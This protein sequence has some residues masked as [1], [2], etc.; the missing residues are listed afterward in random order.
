MTFGKSEFHHF[1]FSGFRDQKR[2][3][4]N[5]QRDFNNQ[6]RPPP[7]HPRDFEQQRQFERPAD[8]GMPNMLPNPNNRQ[9]PAPGRFENSGRGDG[10][11]DREQPGNMSNR[12]VSN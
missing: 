5:Q 6:N 10:F 3:F 12:E 4:H 9:S 8:F 1:Y 2:D 11:R 7:D